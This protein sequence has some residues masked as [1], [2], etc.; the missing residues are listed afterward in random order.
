MAL[1]A[2]AVAMPKTLAADITTSPGYWPG[3]VETRL[4]G[5]LL[6]CLQ[7]QTPDYCTTDP[8]AL[9]RIIENEFDDLFLKNQANAARGF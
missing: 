8:M 3:F 7:A 1:L 2:N 4:L 6:A 5:S 9:H